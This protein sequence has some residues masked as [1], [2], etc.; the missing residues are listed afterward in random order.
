M[1]AYIDEIS[2]AEGLC[3]ASGFYF[4]R[5]QKDPQWQL[6]WSFVLVTFL[7]ELL[8]TYIGKRNHDNLWF[9]N[10]F[11]LVQSGFFLTMFSLILKKYRPYS[12][13]ILTCSVL[14]GCAYLLDLANHGPFIRHDFSH[15]VL[16][17][18]N[19]GCSLYF[20]YLLLVSQEYTDLHKDPTFWWVTG[21]LF[22]YFPESVTNILG[23]PLRKLYLGREN[24]LFLTHM[25]SVVALYLIWTYAFICKKWEP[26]N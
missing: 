13:L 20:F 2:V 23:A 17:L 4:T 21:T 15:T 5:G 9:Y 19:I 16:G 7:V 22:F 1:S 6:C 3:A 25:G 10:L 11:L 14:I 18:A 26:R 12:K 8:G 24:L